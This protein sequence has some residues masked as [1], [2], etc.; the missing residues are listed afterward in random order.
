MQEE[1]HKMAEHTQQKVRSVDTLADDNNTT[2]SH[3]GLRSHKPSPLEY[4]IQTHSP[5]IPTVDPA[6]INMK[7]RFKSIFNPLRMPMK[8]GQYDPNNGMPHLPKRRAL[9]VILP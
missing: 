7:R 9:E 3:K 2:R 5:W 8:T 6:G 1:L 4:Q